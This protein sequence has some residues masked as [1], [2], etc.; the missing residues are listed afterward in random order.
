MDASQQKALAEQLAKLRADY[1][2]RLPD[3]LAALQALAEGFQG[4]ERDRP[5]L[6]VLHQHLHKLA[7]S[8]GTFGLAA[9]SAAARALEQRAKAWLAGDLDAVDSPVWGR[10]AA[11]VAALGGT[12]GGD[13][14]AHSIPVA[15]SQAVRS[16]GKTIRV[17]LVEDDAS[18]GGQLRRQLES[19]NYQVRLFTRIDEAERAA[20]TEMPDMLIMDV[21]FEAEGSNATEVL[22]HLPALRALACPLL[23]ITSTD[24]FKSRVRAAR[25]GAIGYFLKPI[26]IPRLVNR[27]GQLF[28]QMHA[29]PERVLIVDD[30]ADLAAHLSLVLRAAG[31]EAEVLR[32]PETIMAE[33]AAFQPELVLMDLHMPDYSGPELAGVIRQHD[34]WASLPI[35]YLSAETNLERQNAAMR[36]GGDDF[37][38]K[39]ISD[40]QLVAAVSVRVE[41]ARQLADQINKDSLT[42]LLKHA[43]IKEIA[44]NE[45]RRAR[46]IDEPVTLA[47]FDIDHFKAVNDTYGHAAG[48][49]V[50][51][52]LA[53]LLRQRLRQSD[54]LGRYGGEEFLVVLPECASADAQL[55]L[56][57][58]RQRFADL[59]FSYEGQNFSCTLSAGHATSL[60]AA[61]GEEAKKKIAAF[62]DADLLA[63]ADAALY[64][65]KHGGRNRVCA[66]M[67]EWKSE[68]APE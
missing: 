7:G 50:I 39:P 10:M 47:M 59:R 19:F 31:M 53:T 68:E 8:G 36:R 9:L 67:L 3:E 55:L 37:L 54:H 14:P 51:S 35:V 11:E 49:V 1:L 66:A 5:G 22:A 42:G 21:M 4:G 45:I 63:A 32:R 62:Y 43:S 33:L 2:A 56:D 6:E 38:T 26:D 65:A 23:F 64:E 17:W 46:R 60:H 27:I 24:D 61:P 29:P 52:A 20:H 16:P 58:I 34:Q 30:D 48:D 57:D 13:T 41:R 44:T 40:A 15:P 12:L 18:L 25:L 28:E